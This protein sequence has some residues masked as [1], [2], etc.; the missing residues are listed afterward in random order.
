MQGGQGDNEVLRLSA[1][2]PAEDEMGDRGGGEGGGG[3]IVAL[4][5]KSIEYLICLPFMFFF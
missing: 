4:G 1:S 3:V 2:L 5:D